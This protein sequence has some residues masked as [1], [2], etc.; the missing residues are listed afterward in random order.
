MPTTIDDG[1]DRVTTTAINKDA[2]DPT[3]TP[4]GYVDGSDDATVPTRDSDNSSTGM[5]YSGLRTRIS[6]LLYALT[7]VPISYNNNIYT[8]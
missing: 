4:P 2:F 6:F 1:Y 7:Y 5:H 3:A 8:F